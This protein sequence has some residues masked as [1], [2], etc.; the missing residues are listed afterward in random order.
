MIQLTRLVF[1]YH[2]IPRAVIIIAPDVITP[3]LGILKAVKN[4]LLKY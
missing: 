4:L 1:V 3:R 2:F